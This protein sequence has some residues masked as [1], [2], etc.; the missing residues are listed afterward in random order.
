MEAGKSYGNCPECGKLFESYGPASLSITIGA[1]LH[2]DHDYPTRFWNSGHI[3]GYREDAPP[4]V[5]E[6][7]PF[8]IAFYDGARLTPYDRGT[9]LAP[10]RVKWAAE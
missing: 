7:M 1:H 9:F 8:D 3:P 2:E 6:T 10:L 5:P 4:A